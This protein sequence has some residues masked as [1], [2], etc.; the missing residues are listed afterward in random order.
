MSSVWITMYKQ[1]I[2]I[3][4]MSNNYTT[5][6]IITLIVI[7]RVM[8]PVLAFVR[9]R[10]RNKFNQTQTR[11]GE[12][13]FLGKWWD[14]SFLTALR[15]SLYHVLPVSLFKISY[16]LLT[17]KA[18]PW[19]NRLHMTK[20]IFKLK[21]KRK[22]IRMCDGLHFSHY[23]ILSFYIKYTHCQHSIQTIPEY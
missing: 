13:L 9:P 22:L 21:S 14:P 19:L 20:T 23:L 15:R 12:A 11:F 4:N 7:V 1:F 17:Q 8:L 18:K 3:M 16:K 2:I 6:N 10:L 5:Y